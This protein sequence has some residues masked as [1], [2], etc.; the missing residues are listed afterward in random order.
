MAP[1]TET[2]FYVFEEL[3]LEFIY[4]IKTRTRGSS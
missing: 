1:E 4:L 2:R 3:G